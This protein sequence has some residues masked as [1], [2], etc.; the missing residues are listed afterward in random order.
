MND[1]PALAPPCSS[2][3]P[4]CPRPASLPSSAPAR[5]MDGQHVASRRGGLGLSQGGPALLC[6]SAAE[7]PPHR[8]LSPS[9]PLPTLPPLRVPAG[10]CGCGWAGGT[11]RGRQ[12]GQVRFPAPPPRWRWRGVAGSRATGVGGETGLWAPESRCNTVGGGAGPFGSPS[13]CSGWAVLLAAGRLASLTA[14]N[15][16]LANSWG[17]DRALGGEEGGL[18]WA[19]V[20]PLESYGTRLRGPLNPH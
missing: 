12:E 20:S 16:A 17:H 3:F 6:A 2:A 8:R 19:S 7:P 4:R 11:A 1:P 9:T 5:A 14:P 18:T 15:P 13:I 10:G